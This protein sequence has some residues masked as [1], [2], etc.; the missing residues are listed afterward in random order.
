MT[1]SILGTLNVANFSSSAAFVADGPEPCGVETGHQRPVRELAERVGFVR[2]RAM[3]FGGTHRV[4]DAISPQPRAFIWGEGGWR[5]EWDSNF[6][7]SFRTC[8]L[9]I[10]QCRR[11]RRCWRCRGTLPAI[12]RTDESVC[13]SRREK[14][15]SRP[16]PVARHDRPSR[17][18]W[19]SA[20]TGRADVAAAHER[21]RLPG[22]PLDRKHWPE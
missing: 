22:Q 14:S 17:I 10:P 18:G 11:C 19:E 21:R 8:K 12:A 1:R 15:R 4:G 3:R 5:R 16:E 2:P 9:Q 20:L 7:G 6:E 13:R